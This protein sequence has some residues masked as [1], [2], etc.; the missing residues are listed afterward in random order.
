M[1]ATEKQIRAAFANI[2]LSDAEDHIGDIRD[3]FFDV[4]EDAWDALPEDKA[5][6]HDEFVRETFE[7]IVNDILQE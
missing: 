2:I 7:K 6:A 1:V 5:D 4:G 3:A